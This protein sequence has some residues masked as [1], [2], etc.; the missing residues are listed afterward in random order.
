MRSPSFSGSALRQAREHEGK[1]LTQLAA[2]AQLSY[3]SLLNY[4]GGRSVPSADKAA[5]LAD[6]LGIPVSAL[7]AS[8]AEAA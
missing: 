2:D 8:E 7:F 3:P 1:S 6:A 5:R 4:E